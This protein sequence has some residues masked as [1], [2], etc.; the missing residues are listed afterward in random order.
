[1]ALYGG[2]SSILLWVLDWAT[3][4]LARGWEKLD[5]VEAWHD[6]TEIFHN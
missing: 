3:R 1:M 5:A 6:R 4:G 2:G